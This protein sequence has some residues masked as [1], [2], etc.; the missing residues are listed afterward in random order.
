MGRIIDATCLERFRRFQE[1]L[2][3]ALSMYLVSVTLILERRMCGQLGKGGLTFEVF[4]APEAP[5]R[6]IVFPGRSG[7]KRW[8]ASRRLTL[9]SFRF[10][11]RVEASR[12]GRARHSIQARKQRP[13]QRKCRD[14]IASDNRHARLP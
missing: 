7:S 2:I 9:N 11:K 12:W 5:S 3:I 8:I 1:Q 4:V 14:C 6:R 13:A 10:L